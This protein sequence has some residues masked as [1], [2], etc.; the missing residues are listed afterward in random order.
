MSDFTKA[1]L[2]LRITA[3]MER[4]AHYELDELHRR[5]AP[6]THPLTVQKGDSHYCRTC[7][8]HVGEGWW[9]PDSP[10]NHCYY[11][12]EKWPGNAGRFV[13][14]KN[15]D[16]RFFHKDHDHENETDDC[17]LFCGA[18]EERK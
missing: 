11:F 13:D 6:C 18:P 4:A 17:C 2:K 16:R 3:W 7:K 15:G 1:E 8:S 9:C 14:L 10:D 5:L 12:T